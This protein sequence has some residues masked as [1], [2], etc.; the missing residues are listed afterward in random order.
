MSNQAKIEFSADSSKLHNEFSRNEARFKT[1][2]SQIGNVFSS[3]NRYVDAATQH[4]G[5]FSSAVTAF[6]SGAVL[7]KMFSLSDFMPLDSALIMIRTNLHLS[8]K[9]VDELRSKFARLAGKEGADIGAV[10]SKAAKL[11]L[12]YKSGDI[13][14]ILKA[15]AKVSRGLGEDFSASADMVVKIMKIY[16]QGADD[17]EDIADSIIATR[18]PLERMSTFFE[19]GVMKGAASKDYKEVLAV[20]AGLG[21]SGIVNPR[22]ETQIEALLHSIDMNPHLLKA[23]GIDPFKVD[24][25]SGK[26]VNKNIVELLPDFEKQLQK[27]RNR[28]LPE[29]VIKKIWNE[30]L[31]G[32]AYEGITFLIG[33]QDKLKKGFEDLAQA[34]TKSTEATSAADEKWET[35][36]ARIRQNLAGIKTDLACVYDLAKPFVKFMADSPSLT[37]TLGYGAASLALAIGGGIIYGQARSFL[38]KVGG[39]TIT[40]AAG[41]AIKLPAGVA[42]VYVRG[43]YITIENPPASGPGAA[44]GGAG[45]YGAYKVGSKILPWVATLGLYTGV[46]ALFLA[47]EESVRYSHNKS[48]EIAESLDNADTTRV[49]SY[50]GPTGFHQAPPGPQV[51]NAVNITLI[52]DEFGRI[53]AE[54][55]DMNTDLNVRKR[56]RFD[57]S[58]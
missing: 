34:K 26:K 11:S 20:V 36:L 15:G 30:W 50:L 6:T 17:A 10:F 7:K 42:Q 55:P 12:G 19:R 45:A 28:N 43:G 53:I 54:T 48:Q 47:A 51:K 57:I 39:S 46:G 32:E 49:T 38:R 52:L 25:E 8:G 4:F 16:R 35:Q 1:F 2:G 24:P 56:G 37:K 58:P 13:E 33:H 18:Q 22:V 5:W 31:G 23:S 41:E 40:G 21:K 3:V 29:G 44:E 14:K 9:E 27:M